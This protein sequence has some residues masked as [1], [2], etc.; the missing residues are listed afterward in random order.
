MALDYSITDLPPIWPGK[1]TAYPKS[2]PFK[3]QWSKTT[4]LLE[5]ELK[6][7]GAR[8]VQLALEIRNERDLRQDGMRK[9][10]A[11]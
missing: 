11:K 5:R 9:E 2:A 10:R 6:L 3:T 8:Q 7:L 1:K 4:H